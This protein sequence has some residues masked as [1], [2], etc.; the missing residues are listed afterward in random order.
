M[1][2]GEDQLLTRRLDSFSKHFGKAPDL[3]VFYYPAL[4]LEESL[5][6]LYRNSDAHQS[7][8]FSA[9]DSLLRSYRQLAREI[10]KR[11]KDTFLSQLQMAARSIWRH[12]IDPKSAFLAIEE[13]KKR[14]P[15]RYLA[16]LCFGLQDLILDYEKKKSLPDTWNRA[17]FLA[18][19]NKIRE[20]KN[21]DLKSAFQAVGELYSTGLR[22]YLAEHPMKS[23]YETFFSG[24]RDLVGI[25]ISEIRKQNY[26]W[27]VENLSKCLAQDGDSYVDIAN[28][29]NLT[30]ALLKLGRFHEAQPHLKI[31]HDQFPLHLEKGKHDDANLANNYFCAAIVERRIGDFDASK[32]FARASLAA[33]NRTGDATTIFSPIAFD[34][35]SRNEFM[36]LVSSFIESDETATYP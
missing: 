6:A 29:Y 3:F 25:E 24:D 26:T 21:P 11:N 12:V 7:S 35:V 16:T 36:K 2:A 1:P 27:V 20:S 19:K 5:P 33:A 28:R 32:K 8:V 9:A 4:S 22:S 14:F 15:N 10:E 30:H 18:L 17:E 31:L 13:L 23:E 34:D